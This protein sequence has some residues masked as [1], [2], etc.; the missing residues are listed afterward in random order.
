MEVAS[1]ISATSCAPATPGQARAFGPASLSNLGPGF[2]A[3]G[4]CIDHVGDVVEAR[5]TNAPGVTVAAIDGDGGVL[6]RAAE[7][8]TAA[9]A[10][11]TV[12][13]RAGAD[14]GVELRIEKGVPLGSG[15]GGSAASAVAGAWAANLLLD[16]PLPKDALVEAVLAGE[17]LASG[18][19]HGD[20]VLPA[21]F[22]GLVLVSS[23]DPTRYRHVPLPC[24]LHIAVIV[25][26]VQILT[27]QARAMLPQQVGL[28]DA[29]HNAA[30]LGFLLDAFR[31]GDWEAVGHS[32]MQDRLVEPVRATLVP[33]YGA[34][35]AAA[36]EAG[37]FGC[38]LTGSGPAMFALADDAAHTEQVLAA[39]L[40]AS[41]AH[42]IDALALTTQANADGVRGA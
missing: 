16:E 27:K 35:R 30:E 15:I 21:L 19:R 6:P 29:V 33:C 41:R 9:R 36:L 39:M 28:R 8:N 25:P 32:I 38:A 10:A 20:N 7:R 2:D 42:G 1:T 13:D 31:A 11:Q 40:A 17:E 22:G 23:S 34:V 12:L 18:S 5:R 24:D 3:L 26:E 4:L 14:F 37:A